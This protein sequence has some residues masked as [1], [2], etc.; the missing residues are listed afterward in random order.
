M[1]GISSVAF[2]KWHCQRVQ[3]QALLPQQMKSSLTAPLTCQHGLAVGK[4]GTEL[5]IN[6]TLLILCLLWSNLQCVLGL[7][8]LNTAGSLWAVSWR[9]PELQEAARLRR[10]LLSCTHV[11]WAECLTPQWRLWQPSPAS[12]RCACCSTQH[13]IHPGAGQAGKGPS[14]PDIKWCGVH[15]GMAVQ[16][17]LRARDGSDLCFSP[18]ANWCLVLSKGVCC[19]HPGQLR[20]LSLSLCLRLQRRI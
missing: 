11:P 10:I 9:A 1:S 7:F 18:G 17:A 6:R 14:K 12:W 20:A 5:F 8:C 13:R 16:D 15:T 4:H 19:S 2:C 3:C